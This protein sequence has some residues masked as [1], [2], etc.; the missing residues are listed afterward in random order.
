MGLFSRIFGKKPK[1]IKEEISTPKAE[2]SVKP[3]YSM[4]KIAMK[5]GKRKW[6]STK[7]F[8]R[9]KSNGNLY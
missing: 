9:V 5:L 8:N 6:A 2:I 1:E 7:G 4:I 3:D